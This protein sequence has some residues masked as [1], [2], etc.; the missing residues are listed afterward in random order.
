MAARKERDLFWVLAAMGLTVIAALV[1]GLFQFATRSDEEARRREETVITNGVTARIREIEHQVVPNAVWDD[2]V[3][4]LDNRFSAAWAHDN[5]GQFYR[6]T[7]DFAFAIVLDRDNNPLYVMRDGV[8]VSPT[9][10]WVEQ[11]GAVPLI[12]D[13]RDQEARSH[14]RSDALANAVQASSIGWIDDRLYIIT[15]TLVQP[16]FG[17]AR[18]QNA[19]APIVLTGRELDGSFLSAF[20]E[21]YLLTNLHIHNGDSRIE[22]TEAHAQLRDRAGAVVASLDWTPQQPGL[23]LLADALP[24]L[25]ALLAALMGA[26]LALYARARAARGKLELSE[27]RATFIARH[28]ALTGMPNR[29][30]F[31]ES[32]TAAVIDAA[33]TRK[34]FGVLCIDLDRFKEL[35]DTY[36]HDV[37]DEALRQAGTRIVRASGHATCARLDGDGFAILVQ[38]GA[39]QTQIEAIANA[40]ITAVT[41]PFDLSIGPRV[42]G[43]SVGIAMSGAELFEPLEMLRR[44][45]LA[46]FRAK[47]QGRGCYR[48]FD[49]AMDREFRMRRELRDDLRADIA[50]GRLEMVYQ[51]Q[52]RLSGEVVGVESLVRWTHP[53][54]G[55]ISPSIF[56]PLAEETGLIHAL[57]EFTLRRAAK[58]GL[59]WPGVKTAINVSATQLQTPGFVETVRSAIEEVG[60]APS[61][62]EIELTEGVLYTNEQQ[63]RAALGALHDAGFSI[64][65]DDFGTGYSSLSY[66]PRFPIDK[67]KI[68]RSFVTELGHDA[69]SDALFGAIVRLAQSLEM[70][71]IAE[72]VE[73]HEQWLRLSAAGCPKVQ[74]YIAS[75]PLSADD[76]S[77]FI[78]ASHGSDTGIPSPQDKLLA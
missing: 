38:D 5:I 2:A 64:A 44:A 34:D 43:C 60:A 51:P 50:A 17:Y 31:E 56:V 78:D 69:K 54:L 52:V 72:G 46:L 29:M 40:V 14:E 39:T 77:A 19:N 74:G 9:G 32:L 15:A 45:D 41:E 76:V 16:D 49:D 70:R 65:L 63:M 61:Q 7:G 12:Q 25:L 53:T 33:Q 57:G 73:T 27:E 66:L 24:A 55:P 18:V 20:G 13:V 36:G 1:L 58:D 6:S 4:N 67:I 30:N 59:R 71:V 28:D 22:T 21:R 48:V 68:D 3:R 8:D 75:K 23:A 11:D 42:I 35:N 26:T 37:G 10:T 62:I 47:A